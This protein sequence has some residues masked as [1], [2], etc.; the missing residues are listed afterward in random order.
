MD[1]A[2]SNAIARETSNSGEVLSQIGDT[3]IKAQALQEHTEA[4]NKATAAAREL[5]FKAKN[6]PD[7]RN[8]D[9]YI[10]ELSAIRANASKGLTLRAAKN[11]FETDFASLSNAALMDIKQDSRVKMVKKGIADLNLA[12]DQNQ[13]I[14]VSEGDPIRQGQ[15]VKRMDN[16]IDAHIQ[17]GY[18]TPDDGYKLKQAR[19]ENLGVKKFYGD[20]SSISSPAQADVIM[21]N[22]RG[23]S[24][25]QNGTTID[26]Q[27]KESMFNTLEK[28]KA[29]LE[30]DSIKTMKVRQNQNETNWSVAISR[31]PEEIAKLGGLNGLQQAALNGDIDTATFERLEKAM[32]TTGSVAAAQKS[33]SFVNLSESFFSLKLDEDGIAEGNSIDALRNFRNAVTDAYNEKKIDAADFQNWIQKTTPDYLQAQAPKFDVMRSSI[34]LLKRA[35]RFMFGGSPAMIAGMTREFMSRAE[36]AEPEDVPEIAGDVVRENQVKANP[37]MSVL[38]GKEGASAI[39]DQNGVMRRTYQPKARPREYTVGEPITIKGKNYVVTAFDPKDGEPLL[40]LV[41]EEKKPNAAN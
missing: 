12:L 5:V 6:D 7:Y 35:G 18:L 8:S 15:I 4:A 29:K 17:R 27:K 16:L 32:T 26:P 37:E 13:D 19:I 38:A 22:L 40:E 9:K 25:E 28:Y 20:L 31:G 10:Q 21:Q 3:M 30:A 1:T 11:Q 23:G 24:Y 39:T 14:Y 41:A 33:T 34:E 36:A 2:S